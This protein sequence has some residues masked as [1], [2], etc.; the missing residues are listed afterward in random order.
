MKIEFNVLKSA[1]DT[2]TSTKEVLNSLGYSDSPANYR[3]IKKLAEE[4]EIT[5]P[6][7]RRSFQTSLYTFD[8]IFCEN[9]TYSAR[10]KMRSMLIAA[11]YFEDRCSECGMPPEWQN[12]T[13]TLQL[14]HINGVG[15]DNRLDNLRLLC[16][17]CHSQT[18]TFCG[19][20]TIKHIKKDSCACGEPKGLQSKNCRKCAVRSYK[21]PEKISWPEDEELINLVSST[22]FSEAGRQLGVD[23]NSIRK[24]LRSKGYDLKS[25]SRDGRD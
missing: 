1:A 19:K 11:G 3:A 14:D 25:L 7:Y 23:G 10:Q 16:P 21:T 20:K 13:L 6:V 24:R 2:C 15:N 17:N 12:K 4:L 22:N 5:L 18:D 9:S 8:E